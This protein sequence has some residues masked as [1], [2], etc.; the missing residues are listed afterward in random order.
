MSAVNPG[1]RLRAFLKDTGRTITGFAR[2][3][4]V[5][6]TMIGY[7]VAG[8]RGPS[9]ALASAIET[10]SASWPKGPIRAVEW[11]AAPVKRG[12]AA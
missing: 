1:E 2:E 3:L 4:G 9:V 5:S 12:G 11:A 8:R 6:H 10:L 7:L